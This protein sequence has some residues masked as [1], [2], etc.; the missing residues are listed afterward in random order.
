MYSSILEV[1]EIF[2]FF[3]TVHAVFFKSVFP[4][5]VSVRFR[6]ERMSKDVFNS[7]QMYSRCAES[8]HRSIHLR[9]LVDINYQFAIVVPTLDVSRFFG[10]IQSPVHLNMFDSPNRSHRSW[11]S[12]AFVSASIFYTPV[13]NWYWYQTSTTNFCDFAAGD[14]S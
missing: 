14:P 2:R 13:N 1:P 10:I 5:F 4:C 12:D 11:F 7:F 6:K 3:L 8:A 9:L